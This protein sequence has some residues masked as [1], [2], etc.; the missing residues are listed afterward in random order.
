MGTTSSKTKAPFSAPDI[1]M[2][3]AALGIGGYLFAST[4]QQFIYGWLHP[5][6]D[7]LHSLICLFLLILLLWRIP[8]KLIQME[9]QPQSKFSHLFPLLL[10]TSGIL[11]FFLSN[12]LEIVSLQQI[13]MIISLWG[14]LALFFGVRPTGYGFFLSA[15]LVQ[16]VPWLVVLPVTVPLKVLATSLSAGSAGMLGWPVTFTQ[17]LIEVKGEIFQV[18]SPCS[19]LNSI[20]GLSFAWVL[21]CMTFSSS[22]KK[23]LVWMPAIW[24]GGVLLNAFRLFLT[25]AWAVWIGTDSAIWAHDILGYITFGLGLIFTIW[26]GQRVSAS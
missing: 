1:G 18:T 3:I 17:N 21:V 13:A 10:L 16:Q 20:V 15:F 25:I 22:F 5:A 6:E 14:I 8:H 24:G 23:A 26:L 2:G 4:F 12:G 7:N 19:G 11:L 9:V